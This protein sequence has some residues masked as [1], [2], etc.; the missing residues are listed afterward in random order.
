M[1]ISCKVIATKEYNKKHRPKS[2]A[3]MIKS[4]E[5]AE[6]MRFTLNRF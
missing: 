1:C 4:D 2:R 6:V 3:N 5:D